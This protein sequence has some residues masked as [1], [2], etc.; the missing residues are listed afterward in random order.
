MMGCLSTEAFGA[1]AG[2][3]LLHGK[4]RR[5]LELDFKVNNRQHLFF[6]YF[7][8]GV[9]TC[10]SILGRRR[11]EHH[12]APKEGEGEG[13]ELPLATK[14]SLKTSGKM[15]K[16]GS[17]STGADVLLPP[18]GSGVVLGLIGTSWR[19][20]GATG[21]A[22]RVN[23]VLHRTQRENRRSGEAAVDGR[24]GKPGQ[25]GGNGVPPR[26]RLYSGPFLSPR[27]VPLRH[28]PLLSPRGS[29]PA[30]RPFLP[31]LLSLFIPAWSHV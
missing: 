20:A 1:A 23:P 3:M 19:R 10:W 5:R 6:F 16:C 22:A 30:R 15:G 14:S 7:A 17:V 28:C 11:P 31:F 26:K 2:P 12:L 8:P 21:Q 29:A 18:L 4:R 24:E 27:C 25:Q 9:Q 13:Q